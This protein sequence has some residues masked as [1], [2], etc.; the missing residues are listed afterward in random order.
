MH[1]ETSSGLSVKRNVSKVTVVEK[2][3]RYVLAIRVMHFRFGLNTGLLAIVRNIINFLSVA[4]V[5]IKLLTKLLLL[6]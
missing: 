3:A 2:H 1:A 6:Q 5:R 4:K